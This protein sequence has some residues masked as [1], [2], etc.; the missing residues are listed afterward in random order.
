MLY[1]TLNESK[2]DCALHALQELDYVARTTERMFRWSH[3]IVQNRQIN[4][5][6]KFDTEN[7]HRTFMHKIG[8]TVS[9]YNHIN[10]CAT[11]NQIDNNFLL[12]RACLAKQL[13]YKAMSSSI[14]MKRN[15]ILNQ[16]L[17][18]QVKRATFVY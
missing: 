7:A 14:L 12:N 2:L 15:L 9:T 6:L 5:S 8:V 18:V 17:A 3:K 16:F 1:H 11:V 10:N 13:T 4:K